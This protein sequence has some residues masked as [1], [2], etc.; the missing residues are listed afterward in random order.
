MKSNS[1]LIIVGAS[2][3][4]GRSLVR[5]LKL[6]AVAIE[7]AIAAIDNTLVSNAKGYTHLS[8]DSFEKLKKARASLMCPDHD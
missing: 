3:G 2:S 5:E 8:D 6:V 1:A 7:D 4:T